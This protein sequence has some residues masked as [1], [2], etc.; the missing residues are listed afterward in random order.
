MNVRKSS[1][2][3]VTNRTPPFNSKMVC[4]N[5]MSPASHDAMFLFGRHFEHTV[6]IVL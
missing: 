1:V 6:V 3:Y 2:N 5:T 4:P